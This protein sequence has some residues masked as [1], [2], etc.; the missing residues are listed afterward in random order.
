MNTD[1]KTIP[2]KPGPAEIAYFRRLGKKTITFDTLLD[3]EEQT[4]GEITA[5]E[6][7]PGPGS[8]T[9]AKKPVGAAHLDQP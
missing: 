3:E 6:P 1:D 8:T 4:S 5:C 2:Y 9:V 7:D